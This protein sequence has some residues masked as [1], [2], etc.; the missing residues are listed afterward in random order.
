[1]DSIDEGR[2]VDINFDDFTFVAEDHYG[3]YTTAAYD[4]IPLLEQVSAN[5]SFEDSITEG[6]S[7]R[8][9]ERLCAATSFD[10]RQDME[11]LNLIFTSDHQRSLSNVSFQSLGICLPDM[12]QLKDELG[13]DNKYIAPS[14]QARSKVRSVYSPSLGDL[15]EVSK[16]DVVTEKKDDDNVI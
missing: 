12:K 13:L 5:P 3:G 15:E 9:R 7:P 16:V 4:K 14:D 8:N 10:L 1:V 6:G 2:D 11:T